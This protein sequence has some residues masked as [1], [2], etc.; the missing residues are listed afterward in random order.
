M[1]LFVYE[2]DTDNSEFLEISRN[3]LQTKPIQTTHNG[4]DGQ[5][6][7]Q[8]L[9][10]RNDDSG[11]YYTNVR[12]SPVPARKVRVGDINYPEA[13]IG[14]KII[15]K[16]EQPTESEWLA[17][18][19]GNEVAFEDI[20]DTSNSNNSY[21]PFWIQVQISPGTRVQTINDVTLHLNAEENAVGS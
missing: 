5:T 17:V 1:A 21:T 14:F 13:F 18:E 8:K 4:T 2:Y 9:F 16:D 19:S 12:L 3:G 11:F 7:E 6:V 15:L 20:G 10:L